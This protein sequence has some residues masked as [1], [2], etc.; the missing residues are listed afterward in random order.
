M[1][2][3][4]AENQLLATYLAERDVACPAC[5][6]NLRGTPGMS[7]P[8]CGAVLTMRI[9]SVDLKLG[10]WMLAVLAVSIPMGFT[11]ILAVLAGLG[12]QR[13]AYWSLIDWG[14]LVALWFLTALYAAALIAICR[15]RP[16]FLRRA[17]AAQWRRATLLTL[18]TT[19]TQVGIVWLM[20]RYL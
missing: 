1:S 13:S 16:K 9:G 2:E 4:K 19:A 12:A 17:P 18:L 15:R 6:Y 8:E 14:A 20:V 3:A 7:C 10:P 11:G 5:Q